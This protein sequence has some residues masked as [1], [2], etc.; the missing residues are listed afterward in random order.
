M[1]YEQISLRPVF[2]LWLY[3]QISLGAFKTPSTEYR[4]LSNN[5]EIFPFF[6]AGREN[7]DPNRIGL[8]RCTAI[9]QFFL[10]THIEYQR[11][12]FIFLMFMERSFTQDLGLIRCWKISI[13]S[14][15]ISIVIACVFFEM[16]RS[17]RSFFWS[18]FYS[19]CEF[20]KCNNNWVTEAWGNFFWRKIDLSMLL[21]NK[22]SAILGGWLQFLIWIELEYTHQ[23]IQ[24]T[25]RFTSMNPKYLI[26]LKFLNFWWPAVS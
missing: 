3:L 23:G 9:G 1:G 7:S 21:H 24:G 14:A 15:K 6:G 22:N 25:V 18:V 13:F 5:I 19:K 26:K 17:D 10:R 12:A 2:D 20:T 16:F 8:L 11:S 4:I